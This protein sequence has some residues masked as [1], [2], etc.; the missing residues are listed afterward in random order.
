M[1]KTH[2]F[3]ENK[4]CRKKKETQQKRNK[5][6][7]QI[8]ICYFKLYFFNGD[9]TRRRYYPIANKTKLTLSSIS[10]KLH[11]GCWKYAIQNS[12]KSRKQRGFPYGKRPHGRNGIAEPSRKGKSAVAVT[13]ARFC[14]ASTPIVFYLAVSIAKAFIGPDVRRSEKR[15]I[16]FAHFRDIL[17]VTAESSLRS[18]RR[19]PQHFSI[20]AS[21]I[22][23]LASP[24]RPRFYP[25]SRRSARDNFFGRS[26]RNSVAQIFYPFWSLPRVGY[27]RA[28]VVR[29]FGQSTYAAPVLPQPGRSFGAH[30]P[31]HSEIDPLTYL[32]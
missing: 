26:S 27:P 29:T 12:R 30:G 16:C 2:S 17:S 31:P 7:L 15:L 23:P 24:L 9:S 6:I 5:N 10:N 25:S 1:S 8:Q 28:D 21:T 4:R 18:S 14:A 19:S 13:R 22:R 20:V 32:F 3:G 11:R